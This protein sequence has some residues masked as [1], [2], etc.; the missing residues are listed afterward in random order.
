MRWVPQMSR[1]RKYMKHLVTKSTNCPDSLVVYILPLQIFLVTCHTP[2]FYIFHQFSKFISNASS[3]VPSRDEVLSDDA[4]YHAVTHH[5]EQTIFS[6]DFCPCSPS[7]QTLIKLYRKLSPH[8]QN[9]ILSLTHTLHTPT[10]Y[11]D[12][13]NK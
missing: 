11:I 9:V 1:L 6:A 10:D 5:G 2:F 7:E 13:G 8:D 3:E 12:S 4:V